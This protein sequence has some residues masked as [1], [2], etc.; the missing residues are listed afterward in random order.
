MST[1]LHFQTR[2]EAE[3]QSTCLIVSQQQDLYLQPSFSLRTTLKCSPPEIISVS[4]IITFKNSALGPLYATEQ[5]D[6]WTYRNCHFPLLVWRSWIFSCDNMPLVWRLLQHYHGAATL[7]LDDSFWHL[8][9][10]TT[11]INSRWQ[12]KEF[13]VGGCKIQKETLLG[14]LNL[15][16]QKYCA[17]I[18]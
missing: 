10:A 1:T 2:S 17:S 12:P 11:S 15:K 5:R 4:S 3:L 8:D 16:P 7:W 14:T 18:S 13:L 9:N 6:S